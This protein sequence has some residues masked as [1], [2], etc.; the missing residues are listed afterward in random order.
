MP[1]V[2]G[3]CALMQIVKLFGDTVDGEDRVKA[4]V[5]FSH[6]GEKKRRSS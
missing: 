3:I 6:I 1:V 4:R 5:I 2:N